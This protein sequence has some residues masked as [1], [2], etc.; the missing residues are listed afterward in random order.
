MVGGRRREL[1]ACSRLG[2][3]D[4]VGGVAVDEETVRTYRAERAGLTA[5][6]ALLLR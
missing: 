2:R 3:V 5:A 1:L 6:A 4:V